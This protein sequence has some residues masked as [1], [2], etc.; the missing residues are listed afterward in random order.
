MNSKYQLKMFVGNLIK[1]KSSL[2]LW[3]N[4]FHYW[5]LRWHRNFLSLYYCQDLGFFFAICAHSVLEVITSR[6]CLRLAIFPMNLKSFYL[7]L[8]IYLF[9]A[10]Y[11]FKLGLTNLNK[12]PS[13]YDQPFSSY[14]E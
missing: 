7:L 10:R 6:L 12:T 4:G 1:L 14:R 5:I 3:T 13:P 2:N 11:L 9:L 8:L